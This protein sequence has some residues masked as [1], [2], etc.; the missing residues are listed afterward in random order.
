MM[1]GFEPWPQI[2]FDP[3][4]D[5]AKEPGMSYHFLH[6]ATLSITAIL[7]ILKLVPEAV[8]MICRYMKLRTINEDL[9]SVYELNH[10][11]DICLAVQA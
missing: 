8:A 2:K 10:D 9:S 11:K 3:A 1:L 4:E 5:P 7:G 6:Q